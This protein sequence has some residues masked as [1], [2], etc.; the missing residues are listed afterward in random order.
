M[1]DDEQFSY[2]PFIEGALIVIFG[3]LISILGQPQYFDYFDNHYFICTLL[4]LFVVI[5]GAGRTAR[6][7]HKIIKHN[8]KHNS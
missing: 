4:S 5:I 3:L 8:N 1:N 7:L 2:R 6:Y